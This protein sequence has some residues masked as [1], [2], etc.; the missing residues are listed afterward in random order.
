M[1]RRTFFAFALTAFVT[2]SSP[3][4]SGDGCCHHCGCR[5]VRKVCVAVPDKKTETTFE[6]TCV[7]ENFCVPGPSK[8][9]GTR[10]VTDCKGCSHCKRVMQPTCAAVHTRT[11]LVKTPV[12]KEVCGVKWEVRTVCCGCGQPCGSGCCAGGVGEA[13]CGA[14][15]C[16]A[17]ACVDQ[18]ALQPTPAE[19][20]AGLQP[21]A[22]VNL[23]T[24]VEL[25]VP[26]AE[27]VKQ[28]ALPSRL[29]N[30]K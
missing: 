18:A 10:C 2:T 17:P 30:I 28:A 13:N 5:Q 11:K 20:T 29:F 8:C 19:P 3:L 1:L 14:P 21:V 4:Q 9:V 22:P 15:A 26:A 6:Y 25:E 12:T 7:C 24:P 23:Q 16:A 27:P